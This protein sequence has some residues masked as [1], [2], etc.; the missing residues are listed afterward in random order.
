MGWGDS[1]FNG[2]KNY[3]TWNVTLWIGNDEG[4]YNLAKECRNYKAFVKRM[5][6]FGELNHQD[7]LNNI[8]THT[9]DGVDWNDPELDIE[10]IDKMIEEL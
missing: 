9:P 2:H 5:A 3:E 7:G 10:K 4:L 6:G 8:A 1:M